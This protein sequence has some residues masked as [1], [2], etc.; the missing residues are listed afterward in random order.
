MAYPSHPILSMAFI[1][2]IFSIDF[3]DN[4]KDIQIHKTFVLPCFLD[5][6][7]IPSKNDTK[8]KFNNARWV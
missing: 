2:S 4:N 5:G 1:L 8:L 7:N 3:F 6:A